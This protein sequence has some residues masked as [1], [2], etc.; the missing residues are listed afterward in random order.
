MPAFREIEANPALAPF[1]KSFWTLCGS[2]PGSQTERILPDGTFDLVFHIGDPFV[3]EGERQPR[4]MLV[5]EIRRPVLITPSSHV[6][7]LGLRFNVGGASPFLRMPL[8]E[9]RDSILPLDV[10]LPGLGQRVLNARTTSERIA[11]IERVLLERM[12]PDGARVRAAVDEIVRRYGNVRIRDLATHV[13]ATTRTLERLFD[14]QVGVGPKSFARLV[15]FHSALK[16]RDAG[17]FDDAHRIHE[18]REFCGVTQ[19]EF[20]RE[21]NLM[22]DAFVGNLQDPVSS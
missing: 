5:G 19:T 6:D 21:Q 13:G 8:R 15:R 4:A 14:Q 7:V 2:D 18:F 3:R 16:G 17:Y 9:L 1:V 12:R 11:L 10:I 20:R 22:N